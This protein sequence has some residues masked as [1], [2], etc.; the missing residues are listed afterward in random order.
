[1]RKPLA[2]GSVIVWSLLVAAPAGAM[3]Q[4]DRGIAGAR[5]GASPAAVKAALGTPASSK[6]GSND[7]G[8]YLQYKFAGGLTVLFQGKTAVT[9]VS[10]T[11]LGD[12]TPEGVGVGSSEAAADKL[13]GVK[14]ETIAGSRTCHTSDF[15][16][17]KRITDF[18]IS[19]GKVKRVT[20]GVVVD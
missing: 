12:R 19:G 9:S 17:G 16:P 14:C 13:K 20:V 4:V 6:S 2:V 7:F 5:I 1:M 11:G 10:T 8:P 15:L 3:I 18:L